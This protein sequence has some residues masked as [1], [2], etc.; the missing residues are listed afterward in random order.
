MANFEK[1]N[2]YTRSKQSGVSAIRLVEDGVVPNTDTVTVIYSAGLSST[3]DNVFTVNLD[4]GGN[5][6][7]DWAGLG[8]IDNF[9]RV[10]KYTKTLQPEGTDFE[11][12]VKWQYNGIGNQSSARVNR[13]MVAKIVS[14]GV[15]GVDENGEDIGENCFRVT[16]VD[17]STFV[18]DDAGYAVIDD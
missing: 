17:G 10:N 12:T 6:I 13:D 5:F 4:G 15:N 9:D 7:T 18:T 11:G 16:M 3:G 2:L 8:E 14:L 1:V